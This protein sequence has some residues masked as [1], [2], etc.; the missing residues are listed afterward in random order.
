MAY[1]LSKNTGDA[2]S[3][4]QLLIAKLPDAKDEWVRVAL[5]VIATGECD[6][7]CIARALRLKSVEKASAALIYWQGAGLLAY[8]DT[9]GAAGAAGACSGGSI[10]ELCPQ[11]RRAHLTPTEVAG[12]SAGDPAVA[13]LVQECQRLMGGVISQAD[14]NILVSMYVSDA[15][16]VDM[17]LLGV[18]H[19][20]AEGKR[21]ARYIER[22][23]LGWQREGIR[24]GADAERHLRTLSLRTDYVRRAAKLFGLPEDGVTRA[25]ANVICEWFEGFCYDEAMIAEAIAYAGERKTVKYVG[26]ILRRWYGKGYKSVRDVMQESASS[27]QNVQ[28]ASA[29]PDAKN[30]LSG[31]LRRVPIFNAGG[32]K[33]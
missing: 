21:S 33:P 13:F 9:A 32:D 15:M 24:T 4:P 20:A 18:A 7:A 28:S 22:V 6:P 29:N 31:G 11:Q 14:T 3:V 12:V 1:K 5:Y 2:V 30:I 27:M 19:F 23:L 26:G 8:E 17:I 10:D 16:P 25:D